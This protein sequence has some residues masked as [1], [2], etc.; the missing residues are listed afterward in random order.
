MKEAAKNST[1]NQSEREKKLAR[2]RKREEKELKRMQEA[3]QKKLGNTLQQPTTPKESTST[4]QGGG[5]WAQVETVGQSNKGQESSGGGGWSQVETTIGSQNGAGGWS[6]VETIS[7]SSSS[8]WTQS[9]TTV[10]SSD[11]SKQND[12][13]E[14]KNEEL[15][16]KPSS[17]P[18]KLSFGLKKTTGFQ[19][20][21]KKK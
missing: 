16:A 1:I 5:G 8:G 6:Q 2:E 10:S 21:L 20:G 18:K 15:K 13:I 9:N 7:S 19:F 17:E 3:M 4:G 14:P 11:T 12:K